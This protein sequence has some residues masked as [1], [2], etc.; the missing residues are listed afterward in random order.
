M[1]ER[2]T[3]MIAQYGE[4]NRMYKEM[5]SGCVFS[6]K[7]QSFISDFYRQ[8]EDLQIFETSLIRFVVETE[9]VHRLLLLNSLKREIENSISVYET[10]HTFFDNLNIERVCHLHC[11]RF[12]WEIDRQTDITQEYYKELVE[13]NG[14]LEAM[15]FRVHDRKEEELLE[16]RHARCKRNYDR[17]K[18]K[19][20]ELY[21]MKKQATQEAL[22]CLQNRCGDICRLGRSL[23]AIMEKYTT[24]QKKKEGEEK[25]IPTYGNVS[26]N[27]P[28]YFP[29]KL[30][31]AIH[32]KCNGKQF[33]AVS[34]AEFYAYMNLQPCKNQLKIRMGEK[35]RVCYLIY[36]MSETLSSQDK[37]KWKNEIMQLLDIDIR[38]YKSKYKAPVPRTDLASDSNQEF[39]KE[40]RSIFR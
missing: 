12:N 35:A 31:S 6:F 24:D 11:D 26:A 33:E 18:A 5:T 13:A 30:L 9:A 4:L 8:N 3:S 20:D 19:L 2:I 1:E 15:A 36:L 29:M 10:C 22:Q 40:M 39:A 23:L 32:E 14:S 16:R 7:E 27:Q 38:Y 25:E 37:E 17:E 34:E 21:G 28:V